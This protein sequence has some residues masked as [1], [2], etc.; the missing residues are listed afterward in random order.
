MTLIDLLKGNDF[1]VNANSML[2]NYGDEKIVQLNIGRVELS[3]A[4]RILLNITS[5]GEFN[6]RLEETDNDK[7]FHL[8][9]YIKTER[10]HFIVEKND[11]ITISRKA[12]P[13]K[14]QVMNVA[15]SQNLTMNSMLEKTRNYMGNKF[16]TY[17]GKDNNCQFFIDSILKSNHLSTS[18]NSKFILQDTRHLFENNPKFRKLSNSVTDAAAIHN[19]LNDYGLNPFKSFGNNLLH[20]IGNRLNIQGQMKSINI[21]PFRQLKF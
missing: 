1:S 11:V 14:S 19:R 18:E 17:S 2:R 15:F 9:L 10:N 21:N 7:L 16:F 5:M 4:L 8:F 20:T 13:N 12:V 3:S 6:K